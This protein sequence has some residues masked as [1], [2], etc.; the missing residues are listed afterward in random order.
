MEVFGVL[1]S[2]WVELHQFWKV[3]FPW[4]MAPPNPVGFQKINDKQL[5]TYGTTCWPKTP[6]LIDLKWFLSQPIFKVIFIVRTLW[7]PGVWFCRG[8]KLNTTCFTSIRLGLYLWFLIVWRIE[9]TAI[10]TSTLRIQLPPSFQNILDDSI[11]FH[12]CHCCFHGCVCVFFFRSDR[13]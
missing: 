9:H 11:I 8:T 12:G 1:H 7:F 5:W 2:R 4:Q 13:N 10:Q 6:D 3:G